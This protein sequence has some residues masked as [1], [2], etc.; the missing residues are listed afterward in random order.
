MS[1]PVLLFLGGAHYQVPAI[2]EAAAGGFYVV[3]CGYLPDDPGHHYSHEYHNI[4]ISDAD[5]VCRLA[6]SLKAERVVP[7]VS[8]TAVRTAAEV[9]ERLGLPGPA[10]SVVERF[11]NKGRFRQIQK[12][13]GFRCPVFISM[14]TG[15]VSVKKLKNVT[16]P[17]IVKPADSCGSRG[18]TRIHTPEQF[19]EAAKYAMS[20]SDNQHIIAEEVVEMKKPQ[21]TGDGFIHNGKVC[22]LFLGDHHYES[23]TIHPVAYATTWPSI[24]TDGEKERIRSEAERLLGLLGYSNGP[25]NIDARIG[26]DDH[27]YIIEMA[28]R[29]G[30]NYVPGCVLNA[31]GA[32]LNKALIR[33]LRGLEPD[34]TPVIQKFSANYI[35]HSGRN[36]RL[37]RIEISDRLNKFITFKH[38]SASQGDDVHAYRHLGDALGVLLLAFDTKEIMTET[39]HQIN[40]LVTVDVMQAED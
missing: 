24:K 20:F 16:F 31:T 15:E 7:Y 30:G 13:N 5:A 18:I 14:K 36:G 38:I 19:M 33:Q 32:D 12:E 10:Q 3:T 2:Q 4:D 34:L 26:T 40:E 1:K 11:I 25:F 29:N 35:I 8:E 6:E 23:G 27:V 37:N 21:L 9:N 22:F 28:P 39:M 17:L